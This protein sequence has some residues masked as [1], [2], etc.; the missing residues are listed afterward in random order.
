MNI[1][2]K[3]ETSP[4]GAWT[5]VVLILSTPAF[6]NGQHQKRYVVCTCKQINCKQNECN[7]HP[8]Y[9]FQVGGHVDSLSD[10]SPRPHAN[11]FVSL[12]LI[13]HLSGQEALFVGS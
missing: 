9:F 10:G 12:I 6:W 4:T 3:F 7:Q 1:E 8:S 13:C 11:F 2:I 5:I